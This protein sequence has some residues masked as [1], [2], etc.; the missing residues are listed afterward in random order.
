MALRPYVNGPLSLTVGPPCHALRV[1]WMQLGE[2]QPMSGVK[3]TKGL[4]LHRLLVPHKSVAALA[5]TAGFVDN[6]GR[7]APWA[8]FIEVEGVG[9]ENIV[10]RHAQEAAE[11]EDGDALSADDGD[12]DGRRP[13]LRRVPRQGALAVST[14][15]PLMRSANCTQAHALSL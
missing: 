13:Q 3:G 2:L 5:S 12:G 15:I 1:H 9:I 7:C 10:C 4:H 14:L 11:V 8:V 6:S